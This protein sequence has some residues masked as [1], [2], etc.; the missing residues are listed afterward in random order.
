MNVYSSVR[1]NY[2]FDQNK[3]ENKVASYYDH[4]E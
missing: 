2:L 3:Y 4:F 1:L